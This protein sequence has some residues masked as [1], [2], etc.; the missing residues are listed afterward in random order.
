MKTIFIST[1]MPGRARPDYFFALAESFS[2]DGYE[3]IMIFDGQPRNLPSHEEIKFLKWPSKRPTKLKD[4]IFLVNLIKTYKPSV[5]ISSFGSVNLM[6]I[7]GYLFSVKNRVNYILSV[8]EPFYIRPNY[9][10]ILRSKFLRIR[11]KKIY[12][13][14][15]LMICNSFGTEEDSKSYYN[16]NKKEFLILHNLIKDSEIDYK[17]RLERRNQLI[18]VGNL[19]KRKGHH[20]L[21]EQFKNILGLYPTFQLVIIGD[22]IERIPLEKQAQLLNISNNVQFKGAIS[23]A[24]IPSYFAD[25]LI[26]ISTSM[27]EAFG[28]VNI[29]AMREG[30]PILTTVTAGGIEVVEEGVNGFFLT[31]QDSQSILNGVKKILKEWESFSKNSKIRFDKFYSLSLQIDNH[32]E[33]IKKKLR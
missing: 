15:T 26:G 31:L 10:D 25:A 28:F 17:H 33:E 8:S 27:H 24:K 30:T 13:L 12:G 5:L 19:I 22:G 32:R 14:A 20:F 18:I 3:V 21:L 1:S 4:F 7:S 16:L 9:I 23:N 29:E 2:K 6:N 11:K